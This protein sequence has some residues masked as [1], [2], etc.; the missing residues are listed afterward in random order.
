MSVRPARSDV[1]AKLSAAQQLLVIASGHIVYFIC[2][3]IYQAA[4]LGIASKFTGAL[5][6]FTALLLAVYRIRKCS[7]RTIAV[8]VCLY[9]FAATFT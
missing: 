2:V 4:H 6:P 5:R 7:Y 8:Y 9:V 1:A 3:F